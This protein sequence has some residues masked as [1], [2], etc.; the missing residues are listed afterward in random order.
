MYLFSSHALI[1]FLNTST[2]SDCLS[3]SNVSEEANQFCGKLSPYL[4]DTTQD[5]RSYIFCATEKWFTTRNLSFGI[6]TEFLD[7]K[8]KISSATHIPKC[9][10]MRYLPVFSVKQNQRFEKYDSFK[11]LRFINMVTLKSN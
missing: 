11:P 2:C 8:W 9:Q 10:I 5:I 1:N 7:K 3:V 4:G 6:H